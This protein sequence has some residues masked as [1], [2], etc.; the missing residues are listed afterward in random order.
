MIVVSFSLS[1]PLTLSHLSLS[2]FL[3]LS[4]LL[5]FSI[6]LEQLIKLR[7]IRTTSADQNSYSAISKVLIALVPASY[8]TPTIVYT[9]RC[10]AC[11]EQ[12][13]FNREHAMIMCNNRALN[14]REKERVSK[15]SSTS[16]ISKITHRGHRLQRCEV[17]GEVSKT[18][19]SLLQTSPN[20]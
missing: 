9:Q 11:R 2:L 17:S 1:S 20:I 18:R 14:L 16:H 5:P 10:C 7:N 15:V 12:F 3:C 8:F 13:L 6:I 19:L 4:L